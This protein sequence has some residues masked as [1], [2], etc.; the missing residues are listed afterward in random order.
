MKT[1]VGMFTDVG[2]A[3]RTF[4]EL[5]RL[6]FGPRDISVV[7]RS[8]EAAGNERFR[9]SAIDA[10]DAGRISASGPIAAALGRRQAGLAGTLREAGVSTALAE[11]YATAVRQGATLESVVVEDRD[12]DRVVEIMKRHAAQFGAGDRVDDRQPSERGTGAM[13]AVAAGAVGTAGATGAIGAAKAAVSATVERAKEAVAEKLGRDEPTRTR[14]IDE[15][16]YIPVMREELKVGKRGVERGAVH[17]DVRIIERPVSEHITLREEHIDIERRPADR[18]P[19]ADEALF[20]GGQLDI[21]ESGEEAIV[22]KEVRVVEEIRLHKV[23]TEHDEVISDKLR[24]TDVNIDELAGERKAYRA[25]F[26]AL[27]TKTSFEDD[28]PAYELGRSLRGSSN[29]RWE[30]IEATARQ[31]WEAKRPGTWERYRDGIRYAW[32]RARAR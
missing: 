7:T 17:V 3:Q 26:D 20:R 21:T 10:P 32:S 13:P 24:S 25:H 15:D 31:H 4:E 28:L 12:A 8:I 19:R 9:L 2:E 5:S 18:A 27:G 23:V 6:G 11:H 29:Q 1:V 22:S 30:E 14:S 16:Q